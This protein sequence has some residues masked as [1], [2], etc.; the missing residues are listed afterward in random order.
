MKK[1]TIQQNTLFTVL[2][3]FVLAFLNMSRNIDNDLENYI[4]T[5]KFFKYHG[6]LD[7]FSNS[8][9][10]FTVKP[11]EPVFYFV[12]F[13]FSKLFFGKVYLYVAAITLSFYLNFIFGITKLLSKFDLPEKNSFIYICILLN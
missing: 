5:F 9:F 6:F 1:I 11:S 8:D 10:L 2:L 4:E 7:I 13:L 12:S 3:L